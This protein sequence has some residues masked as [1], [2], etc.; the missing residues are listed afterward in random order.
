MSDQK[1]RSVIVLGP[2]SSGKSTSLGEVK[3]LGIKGLPVDLTF[4]MSA[5]RKDMPWKGSTQQ[6]K[7]DDDFSKTNFVKIENPKQ[8]LGIID[9]VAKERPDIKFFVIEDYQ[10]FISGMFM[11]KALEPGWDKFNILSKFSYE[12][13]NKALAM[14]GKYVIVLSHYEQVDQGEGKKATYKP[15]TIGKMLDEKVNLEGLFDLIIYSE[16]TEID[17]QIVRRFVVNYDGNFPARTPVDMFMDEEGKPQ[18]H[19][20]NDMRL[21]VDAMREYWG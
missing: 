17:E 20:N 8:A 16:A 1:S 13:I 10:Y 4:I 7:R 3:S 19:I 15:K 11:E 2:P 14:K 6:Y 18:I 9:K 5:T 21:V 12:I